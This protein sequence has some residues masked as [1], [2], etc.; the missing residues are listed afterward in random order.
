MY[1][2]SSFGRMFAGFLTLV[3]LCRFVSFVSMAVVVFGCVFGCVVLMI[4]VGYC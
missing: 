2:C 1:L 4:G 3:F